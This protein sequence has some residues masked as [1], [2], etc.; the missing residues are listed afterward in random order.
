[1]LRRLY[2]WVMNLAAGR[3]A[4]WALAGIAFIESS[5]F[6]IPPDVLL[7]PMVLAAR[8]RAWRIAAICTAASVA[9]GLLGYAIGYFLYEGVGRPLVEFYGYGAQFEAFQ[10]RYNEWGSWIVFTFGLTPFPYKVITIA[11]GVTQLDVATFVIAS[12]LA[13]GLRFFI[14]AGLLWYWGEPIRAFIE[15]YL[16]PLTILFCVLL[17]AGFV[18]LKYVF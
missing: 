17:L 13:R 2:D 14:V 4:V 8:D 12:T 5:V 7:I 16:G 9:G 11:S 18:L 15:R 1:M 3:H 10:G 6:P